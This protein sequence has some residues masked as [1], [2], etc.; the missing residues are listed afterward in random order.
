VGLVDD[1]QPKVAGQ[2]VEDPAAEARVGQ[3]LRRDQEDV[4]LA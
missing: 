2:A 1:E 4:D 3:T